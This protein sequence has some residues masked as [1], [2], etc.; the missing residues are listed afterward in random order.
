MR[1]FLS[2]AASDTSSGAGIQQDLKMAEKLGF[3]SLSVISALTSQNFSKISGIEIVNPIFF[4]DQLD[5]I[6]DSFDI[7]AV[8]IGVI[9]TIEIALILRKYLDKSKYPIVFDPV[10]KSSS[11]YDLMK[12]DPVEIIEILSSLSTVTTPN[13]PEFEYLIKKDINDNSLKEIFNRYKSEYFYIKGGH[14]IQDTIQEYL[15][16]INMMKKYE[17]QRFNWEY[18]HGTGCAFSSLLSMY[19]IDN[20]I[21]VACVKARE[22]LVEVFTSI[23][24]KYNHVYYPSVRN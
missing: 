2:I 20:D 24:R 6:F 11:N 15:I 19:L 17:Y 5:I 9:P 22:M 10:I 14:S 7:S 18:T 3:W 21:E 13:I 4:K 12:D 23:A 8:K 1:Y 16:S